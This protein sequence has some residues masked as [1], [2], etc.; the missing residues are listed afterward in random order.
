MFGAWLTSRAG[1][2]D[3]PDAAHGKLLFSAL[4]DYPLPKKAGVAD[5][6]F[7]FVPSGDYGVSARA[8]FAK[9]YRDHRK[10]PVSTLEQLVSVL[11]HDVTAGGVQ[12]IREIVIVCHGTPLA[13]KLPLVAAPG[14]GSLAVLWDYSMAL[15]QKQMRDGDHS[16]LTAQRA[17]VVQHLSEQS[18]VTVRACNFGQSFRG[19][20]ALYSF[21]GGRA[22]V[23]AP[24]QFQFF[25]W[26]HIT[27]GSRYPDRL[28]VHDH[29]ARQRFLPTDKHVPDRQDTI[30]RALVDPASF[31]EPFPI[32]SR[33]LDAPEPPE[34]TAVLDALQQHRVTPLIRSRFHDAG[35]DLSP[36]AT[37]TTRV[38]DDGWTVHDYVKHPGETNAPASYPVEYVI[39]AGVPTGSN[40]QD[41]TGQAQL[42][43]VTSA[44]EQFYLQLLLGNDDHDTF[45]GRLFTLGTTADD[46]PA[47]AP[48][49]LQYDAV[50]AL[51]L[52]NPPSGGTTFVGGAY[53][54][55]AIFT[56]HG[57]ELVP[58]ARISQVSP[59]T[60][61]P[62]TAGPVVWRIA[63]DTTGTAYLV[64]LEHLPSSTAMGQTLW[65]YADLR[66]LD[67]LTAQ[68]QSLARIGIDQDSPGVELTAFMDRFG[69]DD[70]I[71]IITYLRDPYEPGNAVYIDHAQQAIRRKGD[72]LNWMQT[73]FPD[74]STV[75]IPD[76]DFLINLHAW[77]REDRHKAV[78]DFTFDMHWAEPKHFNRTPFAFQDDL[79]REESLAHRFAIADLGTRAALVIEDDSP[80][81][82][83]EA[84]KTAEREGWAHFFAR[85]D[86]KDR[87]P[88]LRPQ[89]VSCSDFRTAVFRFRD[90]AG[91]PVEAMAKA[92]QQEKADDGTDYLKI[93]LALKSK[94]SLLR[95]LTKL[96][97]LNEF[98]K[99]P[100][101]PIPTDAYELGK[102]LAKKAAASLGW[103]VVAGVLEKVGEWDFVITIPV[104]ML[105]HIWE[106]EA[107][108]A[109]R[110]EIA[111]R[112]TALRRALRFLNERTYETN[113]D[114]DAQVDV[115]VSRTGK[116]YW[117]EAYDEE[118]SGPYEQVSRFTYFDQEFHEG[119]DHGSV[120]VDFVRIDLVRT[121]QKLAGEALQDAGLSGC[122]INALVDA[123]LLDWNEITAL[124][125]RYVT[126]Y[127]LQ[128]VPHV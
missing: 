102:L 54:I 121:A 100:K 36:G 63:A 26:Q 11:H 20:Y 125:L 93:V 56:D 59:T 64:K 73:R 10:R 96:T 118:M 28:A 85:T 78:Y 106:E 41:V 76:G 97:E 128:E 17:V 68:M 55:R 127:L 31:S 30:V 116:A 50:L 9:Y 19:L 114:L 33:P 77:E 84:L 89:D 115:T 110:A 72:Y 74:F 94:Y 82:D 12:R 90:L 80:G 91:G 6:V 112:L 2:G 48:R 108:G 27:P 37:V 117:L 87:I 88:D 51:L 34:F 119:F 14:D 44:H 35:F 40:T 1:G 39:G 60:T 22:D 111:G 86:S 81:M 46:D 69:Y 101:I 66:P 24:T 42:V 105:L 92:L 83:Q 53:D 65:V 71:D 113:P 38:S 21:F 67:R 95:N 120:F 5:Y 47:A 25:G 8:F 7:D 79:F 57:V 61:P 32:T 18:W 52:A 43:A 3:V 75:P 98:L 70:L 124:A 45:L 109:E 122:Q 58:D 15:L 16:T 103:E 62:D 99:L 107:T 104:K 49:K 123:G 29:L 4:E 126:D 23:Y 13:L